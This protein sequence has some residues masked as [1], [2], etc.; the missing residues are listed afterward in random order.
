MLLAA[1]WLLQGVQNRQKLF[2]RQRDRS[3]TIGSG[4]AGPITLPIGAFGQ[5][6]IIVALE[7]RNA[8]PFG[9]LKGRHVARR[10]FD[11]IDLAANFNRLSDGF[12]G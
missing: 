10:R 5:S 6:W 4:P 12:L 1:T 9:L 2:L 7:T 8:E 11:Q 3:L